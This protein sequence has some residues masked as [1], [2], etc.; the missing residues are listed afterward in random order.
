MTDSVIFGMKLDDLPICQNA[1]NKNFKGKS[2]KD[3]S[4]KFRTKTALFSYLVMEFEAA[5]DLPKSK[6]LCKRKNF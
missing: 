1:L 4:F 5:S 6:F 3:K 2:F